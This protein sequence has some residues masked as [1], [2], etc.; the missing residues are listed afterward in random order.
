MQNVY[1][2]GQKAT[3]QAWIRYLGSAT[4]SGIGFY[5]STLPNK[6]IFTKLNP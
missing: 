4:L 3:E 2:D 5:K 6:N 1:S